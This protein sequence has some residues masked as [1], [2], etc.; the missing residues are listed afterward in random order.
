MYEE[1]YEPMYE[2]DSS[3]GARYTI[4]YIGYLFYDDKDGLN[5][6]DMDSWDEVQSLIN[7]YPE[8][9]VRDNLYDVCW[10]NGEWF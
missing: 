10:K 1:E 2:E 3:S 4:M 7:A 6:H 8:I 9:E 5:I